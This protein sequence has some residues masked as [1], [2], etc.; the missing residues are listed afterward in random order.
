MPGESLQI[1]LVDDE[2][3]FLDAATAALVRRGYA[4]TKA[5]AAFRALH[6]IERRDFDAM[7]LD[8]QMPGMNGF[9]L[10]VELRYRCPDTPAIVLSGHLTPDL[11]GRLERLGARRVL[12]K[13]CDMADLDKAI[14]EVIQHERSDSTSGQKEA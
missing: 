2:Q 11:A 14:R 8:V 7:V 13:P 1:L 10:L 3:P 12:P 4:V 6:Y 9:E 5:W